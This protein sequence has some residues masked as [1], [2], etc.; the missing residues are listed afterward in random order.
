MIKLRHEPSGIGPRCWCPCGTET[1]A[2]AQDSLGEGP[3][4]KEGRV[5]AGTCQQGCFR[6][7]QGARQGRLWSLLDAP[8]RAAATDALAGGGQA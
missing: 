6:A 2:Q 5:Q 4:M 8:L 3:V 1:E 7:Q